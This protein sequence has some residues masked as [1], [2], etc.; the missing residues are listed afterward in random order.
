MAEDDLEWS[1]LEWL[2]LW[3]FQCLVDHLVS[4][5]GVTESDNGSLEAIEIVDYSSS[6]SVLLCILIYYIKF[7]N[8]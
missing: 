5:T 6:E 4:W 1:D 8:E 7:V 3:A 2:N